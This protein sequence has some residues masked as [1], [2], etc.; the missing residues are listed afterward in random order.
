MWQGLASIDGVCLYGAP[1]G[2][3]RTPTVSFTLD[4]HS[5]ESVAQRLASRGVFCSHG[6]FYAATVIERYGRAPEGV[7]RAGAAI[8]TTGEE[9]ERL[10]EGVREM[11]R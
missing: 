7:V 10:V 6:D 1:P 3:P 4:G 2:V 9:V 8:Y 5:S 11:V